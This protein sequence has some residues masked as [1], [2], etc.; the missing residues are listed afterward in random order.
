[1]NSENDRG[2]TWTSSPRPRNSVIT[3]FDKNLELLPVT[4]TSTLRWCSSPLRTS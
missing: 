3:S 1:M 4:Y 2:M